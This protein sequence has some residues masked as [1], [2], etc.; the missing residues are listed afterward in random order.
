MKY[1][2]TLVICLLSVSAEARAGNGW[3]YTE[4]KTNMCMGNGR[5]VVAHYMSTNP[6][7]YIAGEAEAVRK[8]REIKT[9][10]EA[11]LDGF[12]VNSFNAG[13]A[14]PAIQGLYD[15]ADAIG[16]T[17]FKLFLSADMSLGFT[18][19]DIIATITDKS[20][21]SHYLK[22]NGKP[23]LSTFGAG[24]HDDAWWRDNVLTPLANAGYPVTFIPNFE[25][26]DQNS[27]APTYAAWQTVINNYPSV[28]GL[29]NFGIAKGAPFYS[30]DPNMGHADWSTIE[31]LE[32]LSQ[33]LRDNGKIFM[34]HYKPYYWATCHS[35]RQYTE[36]Q[37]GLGMSSFWQSIINIQKPTI[38][39]VVAW[40]DY[41]E[42]TYIQ[43][44][45]VLLGNPAEIP[46]TQH[47]AYY[48]L[49]KYYSSWYKCGAQPR[50]TK[51]VVFFFYR[52]HPNA[53]VASNDAS[54]CNMGAI[55]DNQKWG[56]VEDDIYVTTALT[57]AATLS[58]TTGG[59]EKTY[60]VP[61]GMTHT[62]I[63][64]NTGAQIIA[65]KRGSVT[66]DSLQGVDIVANPVIYNFN[67][68]SGFFVVNGQDS[69]TW[70]PSD[71][72]KDQ[73]RSTQTQWFAP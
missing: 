49:M 68:Y 4:Q 69:N 18:A 5:Y 40:N 23:V 16:A 44:T 60:D 30:N 66:L 8:Q 27:I 70:F 29:L 32:N 45:R 7:N 3:R 55:A 57:S 46:S 63:P 38:V 34:T 42:S 59:V 43:P 64:F 24:G 22:I 6:M 10:M 53:A 19:A 71:D 12:A 25:R 11:G 51:D 61:A 26:S 17:D 56:L 31:G 14:E 9:A 72:W 36:T 28:D 35:A 52:T 62:K 37:G 39:E 50:I 47:L 65:L 33:A 54:A 41:S 21:N 48:E 58:V 15:A 2:L 1:I 73:Y 67:V 20:S 13:Q